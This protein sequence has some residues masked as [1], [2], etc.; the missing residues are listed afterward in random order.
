MI[1]YIILACL[2]GLSVG[3]GILLDRILLKL[4]QKRVEKKQ[5]QNK[6]YCK[7]CKGVLSNFV[8]RNRDECQICEHWKRNRHYFVKS[9]TDNSANT[10][11]NAKTSQPAYISEMDLLYM[12]GL[13]SSNTTHKPCNTADNSTSD[14]SSYVARQTYSSDSSS[15]SSDSSSSSSSSSDW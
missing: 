14:T 10:H 4:S 3:A 8:E 12:Q 2:G 15:C 5:Q 13:E 11:Q 7:T 1:D 6:R 9:G